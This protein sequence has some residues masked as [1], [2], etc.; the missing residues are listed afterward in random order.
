[1]AHLVYFFFF[2]S[3]GGTSEWKKIILLF[4]KLVSPLR[5]G[6][7]STVTENTAICLLT[8]RFKVKRKT[9]N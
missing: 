9:H 3:E 4:L 1:M 6:E 2:P 5:C 8:S 7:T